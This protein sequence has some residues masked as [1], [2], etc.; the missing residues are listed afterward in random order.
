[1]YT[2]TICVYSDIR[3]FDPNEKRKPHAVTRD[4][5]QYDPVI[6]WEDELLFVRKNNLTHA[7]AAQALSKFEELASGTLGM[8]EEIDEA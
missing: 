1:M 2:D 5:E 3:Y 6:L 7:A 4:I 8:L